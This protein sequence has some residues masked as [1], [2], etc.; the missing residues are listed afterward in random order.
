MSQRRLL[1][2]M[3]GF[4]SLGEP[5]GWYQPPVTHLTF[6][7]TVAGVVQARA[8]VGT[9]ISS[10]SS[11]YASVSLIPASTERVDE[12]LDSLFVRREGMFRRLK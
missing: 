11:Q 8:F 6:W 4:S 12:V 3:Q 2:P 5:Q 10:A 7:T 9:Y 1:D